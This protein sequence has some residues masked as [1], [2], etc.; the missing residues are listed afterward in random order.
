MRRIFINLKSARFFLIATIAAIFFAAPAYPQHKVALQPGAKGTQ[1]LKCHEDVAKTSKL[2]SVHPLLKKG[3]CTACH[4]PHTSSHKN[5]LISDANALC[6]SCHQQVMP[7]KA[8]SVH[9]VVVEGNCQTCH[10]SHGSDNSFLLNKSGNALCFECHKDVGAQ[11]KEVRF[12]HDPLMKGKG[13]LNCH[14]PHASVRSAYLLKNG[15]PPLCTEC[16]KTNQPS[17]KRKHLG[18][19]VADTNCDSCHSAHGSNTRG[20]LYDQVHP[21]VAEN[22]CTA[23]HLAAGSPNATKTKKQGTELCRECHRDAVD[24]I[25][26]KSRVHWPLTDKIGCLNCHNPHGSKQKNLI[27]KSTR[28]TC[29]KCHEDTV[30]LQ[31]WSINNPKNKNL[32]EPVKNGSCTTCHA[33]HAADST[34]LMPQRSLIGNQICGKCHKWE[35]HSTH[36]I[37]AKVIDPRD[38]NLTVECL[39]CHKACGTGNKPNMMPFETTY[40]LCIQCHPERRR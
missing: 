40:D 6:R 17:F 7:D 38:K 9:Q 19:A 33:P 23:C 25:F 8:R 31:Q 5:L 28:E 2:R 29:G 18:Y 27:E 14:D 35:T 37:G 36:P 26:A 24:A 12:K 3:D 13:C 22:K 32:C 16:H 1:C 21:P 34:L 20:I 30:R 15:V 10:N 39:S 11:T 4:D